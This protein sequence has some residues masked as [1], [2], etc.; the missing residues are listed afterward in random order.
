MKKVD[1]ELMKSMN[2]K[3][4]MR[5]FVQ[6]EILSKID[7]IEETALSSA[8]LSYLM[9][10]LEEEGWII[11]V[12]VGAF[13]G[14]RRPVMYSLNAKRGYI[15][16]IQVSTR[17]IIIGIIDLGGQ[18]IVSKTIIGLMNDEKTFIKLI[19]EGVEILL[20]GYSPILEKLIAL[21]I[22]IPGVIDEKSSCVVYS[23]PLRLYNFDMQA[24]FNRLLGKEIEV[25]TFKDTDALLLGEYYSRQEN[26]PPNMVYILCDQGVG[27][28][29]LLLGELFRTV[30]VG[31]ELGH[32]TI[33]PEGPM[34]HCGR[35]GC[36]GTMIS[37]LPAVRQYV[38]LCEQHDQYVG[39]VVALSLGDIVKRHNEGDTYAQTVMKRQLD[40]LAEVIANMINFFNIKDVI[41]GGPLTLMEDALER[42]LEKLVKEKVLLPFREDIHIRR[43]K[44]EAYAAVW[45]MAKD[46]LLHQISDLRHQ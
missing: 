45:G 32:M 46:V 9:A 36:I 7:I 39:D 40:L 14:G 4:I 24:L 1:K 35:K 41:I 16:S 18:L 28:S 15:L 38:E 20:K 22:S 31:L 23:A 25:F 21:T 37:E 19:E 11:E 12:G 8:A 29:L 10:E 44:L 30:Q 5:C 13:G 26:L 17:A 33:D 34:C 3:S 42:R 27:L 6:K 2:K 43:S